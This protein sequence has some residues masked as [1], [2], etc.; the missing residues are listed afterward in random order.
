MFLPFPRPALL[1]DR[2]GERGRVGRG[3]GFAGEYN[4]VFSIMAS[5]IDSLF[6]PLLRNDDDGTYPILQR[7]RNPAPP[8]FDKGYH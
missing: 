3:W 7:G 4:Y 2:G 8:L 5:V 6:Y 1:I